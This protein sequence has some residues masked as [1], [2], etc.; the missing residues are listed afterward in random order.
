MSKVII[1]TGGTGYLG[2]EISNVL[3]KAGNKIY[4]PSRDIE[5]F[6]SIFDTSQSGDNYSYNKIYSFECNTGE[7]KSVKEFVSSVSKIEKGKIDCLINT[8]GSIHTPVDI[9]DSDDNI[10]DEYI[11]INLRPAYYFSKEVAKVMKKN[12]YGRIVSISSLAS[13]KISSGLFFYSMTK[14]A[15]NFL[16]NTLSEELKNNNIRCNTIIPG[17]I[18]TPDN[19]KWGSEEDIK[20]WVSTQ[21]I[22][23]VINNLI[24]EDFDNVHSSEIKISGNL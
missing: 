23:G 3:A 19:R 9:T 7:I 20:K 11:N 17:I 24:S 18:D 10:F 14:N 4:I 22:A 12:N 13:L 15:L 2:R 16:M 8:I 21:S 1:V 5:K 6:K